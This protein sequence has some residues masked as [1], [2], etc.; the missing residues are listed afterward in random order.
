[1]TRARTLVWMMAVG[2]S[3]AVR[4]EEAP[5]DAGR[6]AAPAVEVVPVAIRP[7]AAT[8][9]LQAELLPYESVA[10]YARAN[11]FVASVAVDRGASVRRGQVLAQLV[12]P[13][14]SAQRAEAEA[15]RES[16]RTSLERLRAA[17]QTE[18]VVAAHDVE[19]AEA[20]L[21]GDEARVRAL[22]D[23]EGYLTVRAPFEGVVTERNVHPGALAGPAA[24]ASAA[25]M[26]R[27]EQ[28]ARL[29]LNV[30][31][32]EQLAGELDD[33]LT[34]RFTVR[35]W[36]Q[37]TF[38]GVIRRPSRTIDRRTRTIAV[39]ADVENA[40]RRLAPGMYADVTWPVRRMT[41]S[42]FVPPSAIVQTTERTFVV[43]FRDGVAEPVPVTRGF[44]TGDAVEVFGALAAGDFVARRGTDEIASGA[45]VATR[46]FVPDGG[47]AH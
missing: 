40:D 12:A 21:H 1:M 10:V 28:I 29:R 37:Q 41:P 45:R 11:G 17:S 22:R 18:G 4:P 30:A 9:H 2:C 46:L 24:G 27:V 32:P 16:D 7:L 23:L 5:R 39:E 8:S 33:G 3:P 36:P 31:V 19:L 42:A 35:A 43:R 34:V 44:A 20:A 14:M 25:P 15:R 6:A 38:E 26:F 13:E 47:A